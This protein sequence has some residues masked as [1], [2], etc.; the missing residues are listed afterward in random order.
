VGT[1]WPCG[2]SAIMIIRILSTQETKTNFTGACV[3]AISG[4]VP[5]DILHMMSAGC[6]LRWGMDDDKFGVQSMNNL[7]VLQ[8]EKTGRV[9][10]YEARPEGEVMN[11]FGYNSASM[12]A[13]YRDKTK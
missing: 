4:V 9:V 7:A 13:Y 12:Q 1:A 6:R 11:L 10:V 8:D 3:G 2:G 5:L